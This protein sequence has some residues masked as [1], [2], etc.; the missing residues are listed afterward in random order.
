MI[1]EIIERIVDITGLTMS[2]STF[3]YN[4]R[5]KSNNLDILFSEECGIFI[6]REMKGYIKPTQNKRELK[7]RSVHEVSHGFYLENSPIGMEIVLQ[8]KKMAEIET[9]V[10]GRLLKRNERVI[11]IIDS[12]KGKI[13]PINTL[14]NSIKKWAKKMEIP[15]DKYDSIAFLDKKNFLEYKRFRKLYSRLVESDRET[16]EGFCVFMEEKVSDFPDYIF[17]SNLESDDIYG[18]GFKKMK[19]IESNHG[20]SGVIDY[21]KGDTIKKRGG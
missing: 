13:Y 6:P 4:D 11:V 20:I 3:Y 15:L 16:Q 14:D 18:R 10:F 5:P 9:E 1:K 21:I 12:G 17:W 2:A 8:D 19:A 7:R